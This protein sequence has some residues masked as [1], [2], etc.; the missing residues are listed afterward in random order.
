MIAVTRACPCRLRLLET[1]TSLCSDVLLDRNNPIRDFFP[2]SLDPKVDSRGT[3]SGSPTSIL[4]RC[5]RSRR[6][7][8]SVG[9]FTRTCW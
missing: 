9:R 1:H 4:E 2:L 7:G 3:G 5:W 8:G 6:S